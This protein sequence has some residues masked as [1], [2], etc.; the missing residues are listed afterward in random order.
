MS[1][2]RQHW[3]ESER[4]KEAEILEQKRQQVARMKL[5]TNPEQLTLDLP[6]VRTYE[7][8]LAYKELIFECRNMPGWR[9]SEHYKTAAR[10]GM[11]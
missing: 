6:R 7:I 5:A 11:I 1:S 8:E 10:L 4:E 3:F 9:N 2:S